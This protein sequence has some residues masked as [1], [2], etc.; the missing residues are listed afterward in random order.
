MNRL[1]LHINN[2]IYA[3]KMGKILIFCI[4][5]AIIL[6]GK[7]GAICDISTIRF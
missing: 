7:D 2:A 1:L 6:C 5:Y 3:E 4:Y